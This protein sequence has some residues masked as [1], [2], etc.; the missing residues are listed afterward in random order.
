[1]H[2]FDCILADFE[3]GRNTEN[4][5][6]EKYR[7]KWYKSRPKCTCGLSETIKLIQ[8]YKD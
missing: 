5:Y 3:A 8:Q 6:E 7:G 4:G 2:R 1:V